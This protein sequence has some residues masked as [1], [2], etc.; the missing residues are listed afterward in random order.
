MLTEQSRC[1][2]H[3]DLLDA[4]CRLRTADYTAVLLD[5]HAE[6]TLRREYGIAPN[7]KVIGFPDCIWRQN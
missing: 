5:M 1:L 6:D 2:A 3:P 4:P 7:A